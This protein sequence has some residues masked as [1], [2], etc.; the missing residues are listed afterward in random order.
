MRWNV[1][2][3]EQKD[4]DR[5]K[6]I[7][8]ETEAKL[9][10]AKHTHTHTKSLVLSLS[11]AQ[12]QTAIIT[13]SRLIKSH[14][15]TFLAFFLLPS[16]PSIMISLYI[17]E[18]IYLTLTLSAHIHSAAT[19]QRFYYRDEEQV[20]LGVFCGVTFA[21]RTT[22]ATLCWQPDLC[23]CWEI[24]QH[25]WKHRRCDWELCFCPNEAATKNPMGASVHCFPNSTVSHRSWKRHE[26]PLGDQGQAVEHGVNTANMSQQSS[27]CQLGVVLLLYLL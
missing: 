24:P 10:N 25:S 6:G 1:C 14:I 5:K 3:E 23:P 19:S 20:Q 18:G 26:R 16:L 13:H 11:V 4:E 8:R 15:Y 7:H 22:T 21:L 12:R 9:L 17:S 27:A 2:E